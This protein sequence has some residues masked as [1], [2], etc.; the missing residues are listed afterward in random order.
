MDALEAEYAADLD[1]GGIQTSEVQFFSDGSAR[2]GSCTL[3]TAR[4]EAVLCTLSLK[5]QVI[6]QHG[7]ARVASAALLTVG[8]SL[9]GTLRRRDRRCGGRAAAG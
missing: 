5:C 1:F 8:P 6:C 9:A 4:V 3:H 2:L 7:Y